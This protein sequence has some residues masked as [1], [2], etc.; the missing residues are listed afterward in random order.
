MFARLREYPFVIVNLAL[1]IR[2]HPI[3]LMLR[4]LLLPTVLCFASRN[5]LEILRRDRRP[6]HWQ[7]LARFR[8]GVLVQIDFFLL[9]RVHPVTQVFGYLPAPANVN[10][11][12]VPAPVELSA[13]Q[14]GADFAP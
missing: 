6:L 13:H 9:V 8:V 5:C 10:P 14:E 4:N 12:D 11:L 2:V 3:P 7:R 1:L